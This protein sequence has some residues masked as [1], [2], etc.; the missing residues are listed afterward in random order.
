MQWSD[1]RTPPVQC[2]PTS[3]ERKLPVSQI[4]SLGHSLNDRTDNSH[5]KLWQ[6]FTNKQGVFLGNSL[7]GRGLGMTLKIGESTLD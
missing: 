2:V 5:N 4:D 3:D 7:A 6:V 1:P